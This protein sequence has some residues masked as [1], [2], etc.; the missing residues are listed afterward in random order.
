MDTAG[1]HEDQVAAAEGFL[2]RGEKFEPPVPARGDDDVLVQGRTKGPAANDEVDE[3]PA[4]LLLGHPFLQGPET[5]LDG[6]AENPGRLLDSLD[7]TRRLDG[8]HPKQ[9]GGG[10]HE[11]GPGKGIPQCLE[12]QLGHHQPLIQSQLRP[13]PPLAKAGVHNGL[14]DDLQGQRLMVHPDVIDPGGPRGVPRA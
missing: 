4:H 11:S 2:R 12:C 8:P 1:V 6:A 7:L 13:D 14:P 9:Q 3:A 10:I 5:G